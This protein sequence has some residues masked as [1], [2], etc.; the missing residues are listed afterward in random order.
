LL[1]FRPC[2]SHQLRH[3]C[4]FFLAEEARAD[5]QKALGLLRFRSRFHLLLHASEWK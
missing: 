2:A 5:H 1:A 4:G 3:A